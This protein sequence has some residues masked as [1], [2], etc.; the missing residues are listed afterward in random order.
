MSELFKKIEGNIVDNAVMITLGGKVRMY[1]GNRVDSSEFLE[2]STGTSA[3]STTPMFLPYGLFLKVFG[4]TFLKKNSKI[5]KRGSFPDAS[6]YKVFR[7]SNGFVM[8]LLPGGYKQ[9]REKNKKAT[10]SVRLTWTHN[11]MNHLGIIKEPANDGQIA[12]GWQATDERERA[13][14]Q[15]AGAGKNKVTHKFM[16]VTEKEL[17]ELG[18]L[19]LNL[20]FQKLG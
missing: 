13:Y 1:I 18:E 12:L 8:V 10:D 3:Y 15:H 14:Y 9:W 20:I 6:E 7:A 2:G 16:D 5:K 4:K 17:D 19:A 11:M